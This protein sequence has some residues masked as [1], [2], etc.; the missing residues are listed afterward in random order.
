[1]SRAKANWLRAFNK[2]RMQLQEVSDAEGPCHTHYRGH[3]HQDLP[4]SPSASKTTFN[5]FFLLNNMLLII[6]P[7][8]NKPMLTTYPQPAGHAH[9]HPKDH[10]HHPQTHSSIAPCRQM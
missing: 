3:A 10:T 6:S 7:L 2:V 8:P 9:P 5:T 1:M 4:I